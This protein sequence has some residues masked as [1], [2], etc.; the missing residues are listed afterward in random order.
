MPKRRGVDG[1][2][3]LNGTAY[4]VQR[5]DLGGRLQAIQVANTEGTVGNP[6][7]TVARGYSAKLGDIFEGTVGLTQ[8]TFDE[9]ENPFAAPLDLDIG[10][11]VRVKFYPAGLSGPF[12]D[13]GDM[14]LSGMSHSGSVPGA[15]PL[16]LE[17]ES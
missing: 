17:F 10:Q 13:M 12:Y 3:T 5:Y 15:Q 6:N 2:W 1:R 8:P 11:Y 9:N 14:L 7:G 4:S 16:R